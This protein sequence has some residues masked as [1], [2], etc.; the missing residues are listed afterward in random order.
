LRHYAF[1][2]APPTPSPVIWF[3]HELNRYTLKWWISSK[4]GEVNHE[5][6]KILT[7]AMDCWLKMAHSFA[8][9]PLIR[10]HDN[11]PDQ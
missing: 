1:K 11:L 4:I 9:T 8:T 10:T 3:E 7:L 6:K 2:K 5:T